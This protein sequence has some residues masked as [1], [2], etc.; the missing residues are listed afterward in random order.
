MHHVKDTVHLLALTER[1]TPRY[2]FRYTAKNEA[3]D[4]DKAVICVGTE[5]RR[6]RV[7][8]FVF[9]TEKWHVGA[10]LWELFM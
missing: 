8:F 6:A 9:G 3:V 1:V 5:E 4:R 2:C 7:F 10:F